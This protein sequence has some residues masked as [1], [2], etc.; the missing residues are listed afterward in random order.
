MRMGLRCKFRAAGA[1]LDRVDVKQN[2]RHGS[3]GDIQPALP[4]VPLCPRK[5]TSRVPTPKSAL[6]QQTTFDTKKVHKK[7]ACLR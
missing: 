2:V 3:Q 1:A 7:R 6:G 4:E 5:R